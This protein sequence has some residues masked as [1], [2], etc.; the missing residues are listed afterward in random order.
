MQLYSC[1]YL[2]IIMLD[3]IN[4]RIVCLLNNSSNNDF[5]IGILWQQQ[6]LLLKKA[7]H[8]GRKPSS[9]AYKNHL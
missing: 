6:M 8:V 2:N 3:Y 1:E 7:Q 5:M 9:G 4:K